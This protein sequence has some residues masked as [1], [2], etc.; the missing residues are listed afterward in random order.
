MGGGKVQ[1]EPNKASRIRSGQ[2]C[3]PRPGGKDNKGIPGEGGGRLCLPMLGHHACEDDNKG[4]C[5][6]YPGL[7]KLT[8]GLPGLGGLERARVAYPGLGE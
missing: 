1:G 5:S 4:I 6:A 8:R 3:L 2:G 7:W